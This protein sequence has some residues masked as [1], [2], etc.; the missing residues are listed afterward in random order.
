M[1]LEGGGQRGMGGHSVLFGLD[2]QASAVHT[3]GLPHIFGV[4]TVASTSRRDF[5]AW[6]LNEESRP[7][8]GLRGRE[9]RH[10]CPSGSRVGLRRSPIKP[11]QLRP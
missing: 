8:Q 6:Q 9:N 5:P 1:A 4:F 10:S 2:F 11:A 7:G 3:P